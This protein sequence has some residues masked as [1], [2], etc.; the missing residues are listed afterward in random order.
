MRS[1]VKSGVWTSE[2]W[3]T[4]I[5]N[6]AGAIVALLA[7]YGMVRHEVAA[8]VVWLWCRRLRLLWCRW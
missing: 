2:F 1:V 8:A 3:V 4:A 6:V 7:A 5:V